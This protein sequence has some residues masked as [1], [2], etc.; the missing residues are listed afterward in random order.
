MSHADFIALV[1]LGFLYVG[2][3]RHRTK[4]GQNV[5]KNRFNAMVAGRLRRRET[6]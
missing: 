4:P 1:L 6:E 3:W 5:H 2:L